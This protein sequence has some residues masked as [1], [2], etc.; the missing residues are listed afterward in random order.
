MAAEVGGETSEPPVASLLV[1]FA[2]LLAILLS[3]EPPYI[4]LS[5]S[6]FFMDD[7][8]VGTVLYI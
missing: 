7:L 6:P 8:A 2:D 3:H 1:D 5:F 4:F